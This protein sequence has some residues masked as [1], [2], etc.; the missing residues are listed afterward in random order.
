[1]CCGD[2]NGFS[3]RTEFVVHLLEFVL[4]VA[5]SHDASSRLEPER[6]VSADE[7]AYG[8]GLVQ[9]AVQSDET[10]AATVGS[11]IV[12]FVVSDELQCAHFGCSAQCA[13][14]EGVCEQSDGI[15]SRSNLSRDE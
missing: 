15:C 2:V 14:G 1:M 13:C 7:G 8:D 12:R 4:H 3:Q 9:R 6:S 5:G 10:D 11:A